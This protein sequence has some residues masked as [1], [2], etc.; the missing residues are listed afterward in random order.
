MD[1]DAL[2]EA[3][4]TTLEEAAFLFPEIC[5]EPTIAHVDGPWVAASLAFGSTMC[6]V[7]RFAVSQ[8]LA[9]EMASNLLGIEP[10]DAMAVE[11][12]HEAVGEM[13]NMIG[14]AVIVRLAE[15]LSLDVPHVTAVAASAEILGITDGADAR[16]TMTNED[17]V[18][19]FSIHMSM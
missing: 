5:D 4:T 14:G 12:S 6:G 9:I 10:D 13:L 17:N 19:V 18:I 16:F 15:G 8:P 1:H 7:L 2:I 3:V 11:K